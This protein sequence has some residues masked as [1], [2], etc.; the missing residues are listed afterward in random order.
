MKIDRIVVERVYA[1]HE[2]ER[3]TVELRE[4]SA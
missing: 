4:L 1:P 3:C 2:P